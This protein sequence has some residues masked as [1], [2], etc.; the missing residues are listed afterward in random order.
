MA[1]QLLQGI[2]ITPKGTYNLGRFGKELQRG[3]WPTSYAFGGWIYNASCD[4]GFSNQPTEI[5]IS[6]VLEV[7]DKDQKYA[8]F[9]IKDTDLKCD[10]GEGGDENLYDIDFNGVK[11]TDFILFDYSLSIEA[12]AKVLTVVFKDYSV[13]LDKIYVGLL[14]RQGDKYVYRA[15]SIMEFP[16]IC[17]D[18]MLAGDSLRQPSWAERDLAYGSY[19]GI[20]EQIYDNF[21]DIKVDG[22][23]FSQWEALFQANPKNPSFDL[24][25]GYLILG[26]EEATEE[27]CGNLAPMSYNFNQLLASLRI[28]GLQFEGAFPHASKD[29]DYFYHQNYIGSLRE[30]LQQWCSDLGYDFYCM[31]RTFIGINL[32][33]AINIQNVIDMADPT[34]AMGSEFASNK[35]TAILSYHA[36]TSLA[37]TFKQAVITANNR[38]RNSKIHSKSPKRYVGILPL[39]P[40]DF[41]RHSTA[42]VIR[43]DAFGNWFYD[44]AWANNFE[45]PSSDRLKT[46]PELDGRTF[47]EIDTAIALGRHDSALRDIFCQD[48]ALYGETLAIRES[49]FKALGMVPLVELT[50]SEQPQAKA[51]CIE[52]LMG[53]GGGDEIQS[54]CLDKRY[55]R[56]FIGYY[57]PRAKA[58]ITAWEQMAAEGMYRYGIV[59][60]GLLNHYPYMPRN[61]LT[62]MSP[63]SGLYGD[64][65]TSLLRIQHNVEPSANQYF[66]MRQAPFKD[67]I[68]YSGIHTPVGLG[69]PGLPWIPYRTGLFP[70]GLF[71]C[72]LTND[73][74]TNTEDFKRV[75]SLTLDDPCVQDFGQNQGYTQMINNVGN[76]FQDWKLEDYAPKVSADLQLIWAEAQMMLKNLPN[77]TLYDRTVNRYYDLHYKYAQECSKLHIMVMTDTRNHPNIYFECV[78]RPT[79]FINASMLQQY[80]DREREAVKRRVEM[81]TPTD[82]DLT[83]LQEMCRNLLSGR[84]QAGPT[85]DSRF[86]CI[87]DEDKWNWLEDG[88]TYPHLTRPNSRGLYVR[89]VK[90]PISNTPND[91]IQNIFRAT[92][93]NGDFYYSDLVNQ[94]N[95]QQPAYMYYNI[96]YPIA[97]TISSTSATVPVPP[98]PYDPGSISSVIY[99][100]GGYYRGILTST[101]DVENRTPE[102]VEVYGAPVNSKNNPTTSMKVINN[103]VDPD[104]Q[105]QLDP[106]SMRFWAYMTVITGDAQIITTVKQYHDFVQQLNN[107]ELLT[108]MKSV[109][110]SLAGSPVNFGSFS[111]YLTPNAGLTKMSMS[112]NDNGVVTALTFSDRPKILPKQESILN[113]ITPRIR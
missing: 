90:N 31:G 8:F 106:F 70:T 34:T 54:I 21:K 100:L 32:N 42:P 72:E 102:I 69:L 15:R 55:Y 68:L 52:A 20:N 35:N 13:I 4:I 45:Y 63:K 33:K 66:V 83:L 5:K 51:M 9:N 44:I 99:G 1:Y 65:G 92:D 85:G 111:Q 38:A 60:K 57:Y 53:G 76:K 73:W 107:Y 7:I 91:L 82:C 17:P 80:F 94:F 29:A 16:V 110:V 58:D 41:N 93:V 95:V 26:T 97:S 59:T 10:A 11:F 25:G 96:V 47:G 86:G 101:I 67:L 3:S 112:V 62:D 6:I 37:N 75:M 78:P 105:P 98:V 14:K 113:K 56:V 30:A 103:T 48:R 84:F 77:E 36:N 23:I 12:N 61:S 71:Y 79:M 27:R 46:L 81:K 39:H 18:C 49:N 87:Q 104:L 64:G 28:R 24:N 89:L 22:N 109:E 108:P 2:Q 43:Y 50:D 74:G 19:V 88:F 40:I